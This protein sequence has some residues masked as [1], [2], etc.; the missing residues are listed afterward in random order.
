MDKATGNLKRIRFNNYDRSANLV[1]SPSVLV[2]DFYE[3]L[4]LF[5]DIAN[6]PKNCLEIPPQPGTIYLVDNWRLLHA[7]KAFKGRRVFVGCYLERDEWMSNLR[8]L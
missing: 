2:S 6:D 3:A 5:S 4:S 1:H 7:R 8:M